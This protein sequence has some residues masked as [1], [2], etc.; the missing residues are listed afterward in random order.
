MLEQLDLFEQESFENDIEKFNAMYKMRVSVWPSLNIGMS[1][2]Q[3]LKDF[4]SILGK[5]LNEIDDIINKV[6]I[7]EAAPFVHNGVAVATELEVLTDLAD[8]FGDLQVYCASEMCKFGL[9]VMDVLQ[10]IMQSNFSKMGAN[11][12]PIYNEEG[13]LEKGPNYY[14]PEPMISKLLDGRMKNYLAN[15]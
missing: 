6:E 3:R 14:K 1:V 8:L 9:P 12:L 13:K 2:V 5:E 7:Q 10:I 4:K 11:G 15:E